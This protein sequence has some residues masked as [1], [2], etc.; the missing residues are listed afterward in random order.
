MIYVMVKGLLRQ[1]VNSSISLYAT[2]AW[3]PAE[4]NMCAFVI[5]Q[6]KEVHDMA[7]ERIL[8]VFTL[9]RL[10][11]GHWVRVNYYILVDWADVFV[12][13]QC[14]SDGCSLSSKYGTVVWQSF[15]QVAAGCL[16]ILEMA[17][18]NCRCPH[19]LVYFGAISE[20]FVVLSYGFLILPELRLSF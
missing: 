10:E 7:K 6:P 11:A 13:V 12:I 2:M 17:V 9:N 5:Q 3:Y 19:S 4:T 15:G 1:M 14:Q 16:T 20:D 8:S 18:D